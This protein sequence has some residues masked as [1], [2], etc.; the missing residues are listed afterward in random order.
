MV[1][2]DYFEFGIGAFFSTT[3][4]VLYYFLNELVKSGQRLQSKTDANDNSRKILFQ[5]LFGAFVLG[6]LPSAIFLLFTSMPMNEIGLTDYIPQR[7]FL[8]TLILAIV[9]LPVNY[10]NARHPSNL[11]MY[12]QIKIREWPV[13]LVIVSS[14]SWIV[15]LF[16]YE[17]LFRGILFFSSLDL[18]GLWPAIILNT[19]IYAL[20][21]IQKGAKESLGSLPMGVILCY[22]AYITGSFWVAFFIHITLALSNEWFSLYHH[23]SIKVVRKR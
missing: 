15:Y 8:L 7:T 2:K 17:L 4:F 21:H 3:G 13:S 23:P 20:V 18:F 1:N 22:L 10:F 19:G 11:A 16:A 9:I 14:L 6:V 5:R 12:P